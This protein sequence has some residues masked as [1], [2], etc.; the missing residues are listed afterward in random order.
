LAPRLDR[1]FVD[2]A[3]LYPISLAD[4]VLRLAEAGMFDLLWSD[5]LLD[6]IQRVLVDKKGLPNQSARY[7]CECIREAFP[8]GRIEPELYL[9]LV[10]SRSG[11][12]PDDHVH[13]AAAV[14]GGATVVLSA[15]KTGYPVRDIAPA[16]RRN[17]DA[18]LTALLRRHPQD[19]LSVVDALG[20]SLRSPLARAAVLARLAAAGAP[21]FASAASELG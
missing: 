20:E 3:T 16:R 13:S 19:V 4:L 7:F 2:S 15:D 12:D 6:E 10:A 1:V 18:F 11:P 17:P 5:H 14:A 21:G 9:P 8:E